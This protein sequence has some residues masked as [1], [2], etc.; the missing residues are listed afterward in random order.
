[1][2]SQQANKI[3]LLANFFLKADLNY[4]LALSRFHKCL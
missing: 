1:M 2:G 4:A 3:N